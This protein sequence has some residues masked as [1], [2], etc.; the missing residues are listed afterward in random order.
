MSESP[1]FI[2]LSQGDSLTLS[3]AK[4]IHTA[5]L[6]AKPLGLVAWA[7]AIIMGASVQV[8]AGSATVTLPK[9]ALYM[10]LTR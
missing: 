8:S 4:L 1:S 2:T 9:D 3:K 7:V 10:I 6:K 5:K